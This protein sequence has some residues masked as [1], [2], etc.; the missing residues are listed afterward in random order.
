[1]SD[2][3]YL[4]HIL[5]RI[6]RI[7][8][9]A[10]EGRETFQASPILQDAAIRSFEVIGE[11]VKRLSDGARA[12]RPDVPWRQLAGF[13]DVL[14]H[15]YMGVDLDEVWNS[16]ERDVPSLKAALSEMLDDFGGA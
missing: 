12:L 3:L 2:R 13:R 5:E 1:M 6:A 7:E 10:A 9:C 11:A 4:V 15:Q 16:I 8:A 14:I